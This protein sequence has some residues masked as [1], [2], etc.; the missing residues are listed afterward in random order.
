MDGTSGET[1]KSGYA[2]VRLGEAQNPGPAEHERDHAEEEPSNHR[3]LTTEAGDA[4]PG[5]QD[6]ITRGVRN[7]QLADVPTAQPVPVVRAPPT[8]PNTRRPTQ[9][10]SRHQTA[11]LQCAQCGVDPHAHTR[12]AGGGLVGHTSQK[13]GGQ[14][15][16]QESVAQLRQLDRAA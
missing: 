10:L 1:H 7:L 15:L 14:T 16:T 13:H 12:H 3:T 2:G 5:R 9:Q 11:F 6:S 4:V 8:M